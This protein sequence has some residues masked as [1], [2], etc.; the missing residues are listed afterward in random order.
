MEFLFSTALN[1]IVLTFMITTITVYYIIYDFR[2]LIRN[3]NRQSS[4]MS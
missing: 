3:S 4:Q 2:F 1:V